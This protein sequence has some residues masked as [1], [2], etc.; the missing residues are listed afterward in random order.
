LHLFTLWPRLPGL[1]LHAPAH[2]AGRERAAACSLASTAGGH[3]TRFRLAFLLGFALLLAAAMRPAAGADK[4]LVFGA[5]PNLTAR[6]IVEVYRPLANVLEKRLQRRVVVYSARDFRTFVERTRQGE[7]D[8]LLTAPHLAWLARQDVGYRPLLKHVQPV[9]GLLVVKAD[10]PFHAPDALRGRTIATADA[11]AVTV[12]AMRAELEAYGLKHAIDYRTIDS[13]THT[14]AVMQLINGRTDAAILGRH[15]YKVIRPELR[16]Q[17]RVLA[18]TPPLSS[19]MYLTHPRLRDDEAMAIRQALLDFAA[20]PEGRA[21]IQRGGCGGFTD[22]DGRELR[23]FR[24]YALQAQD[25][26]RTT[27]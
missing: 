20:T 9:R 25:M 18:E 15:P 8:I 19:L 16:L 21:F 3:T 11:L 6:Q 17:L 22:V 24:P 2:A 12:L 1:I 5:F 10:S 7:Y 26:L 4:P 14:N 23:A 13:G 27:R